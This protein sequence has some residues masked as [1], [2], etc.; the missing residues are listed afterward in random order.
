MEAL[1]DSSPYSPAPVVELAVQTNDYLVATELVVDD[2]MSRQR[3]L[4]RTVLVGISAVD[5]VGKTR[6]T[7]TVFG[8]LVDRDIPTAVVHV[9]CFTNDTDRRHASSD[10]VS[11]YYDHTFDHT[12]LV[13]N[14]LQP[15]SEGKAVEVELVHP[16]PQ[17]DS[18]QV[19]HSYNIPPH[20]AVALVEGVFLFRPELVGYFDYKALLIMPIS[21]MLDRLRKRDESL[22]GPSVLDKVL[23]KYVPAQQLYLETVHPERLVEVVFDFSDWEH[24]IQVAH[25]LEETDAS[26]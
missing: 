3:L 24:P 25:V 2:A 8:L 18:L 6:F 21:S 19:H 5:G 1:K 17:D 15:I 10:R 20:N 13:Q 16:S 14:V 4:G 23:Q 12:S 11:N 7:D 22:L 26:T 9:D